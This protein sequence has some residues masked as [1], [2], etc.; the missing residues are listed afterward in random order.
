MQTAVAV[1]WVER[2][3][4][5]ETMCA[6]PAA[7]RWESVGFGVGMLDGMVS[8]RPRA[9]ALLTHSACS[10]VRFVEGIRR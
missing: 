10:G 1:R 7:V 4:V 2:L 6:V 8:S 9:L 5:M 3:K